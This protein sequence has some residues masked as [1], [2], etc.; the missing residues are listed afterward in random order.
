MA[1]RDH[2]HLHKDVE[3]IMAVTYSRVMVVTREDAP[4]KKRMVQLFD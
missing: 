4:A 1:W 2:G 3:N